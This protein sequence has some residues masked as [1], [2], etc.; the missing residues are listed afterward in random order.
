MKCFI[1]PI[2]YSKTIMDFQSNRPCIHS[3]MYLSPS[4]IALN[5]SC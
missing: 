2:K 4:C 1:K 5:R 3:L